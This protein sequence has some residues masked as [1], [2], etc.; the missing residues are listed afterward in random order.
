[1]APFYFR[2]AILFEPESNDE[3]DCV[4]DHIMELRSPVYPHFFLGYA[5]KPST[6]ACENGTATDFYSVSTCTKI[7]DSLKWSKG[8]PDNKGNNKFCAEYHWRWGMQ[9]LPCDHY[10]INR[11]VCQYRR[12]CP[13]DF[14]LANGISDKCFIVKWADGY[15]EAK[16]AK[17]FCEARYK[18]CTIFTQN[19][20]SCMLY[21]SITNGFSLFIMFYRN[22]YFAFPTIRTNGYQIEKK[23]LFMLFLHAMRKT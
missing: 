1:M 16:K 10:S 8:Q 19:L 20:K 23:R 18:F 22:K 3:A 5:R 4:D 7:P 13:S 17:E 15:K 2:D 11:V 21:L 14:E 9:A 12:N 6:V